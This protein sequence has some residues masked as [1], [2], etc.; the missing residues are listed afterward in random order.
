[1]FKKEPGAGSG[2]RAESNNCN[3]ELDPHLD[4][5]NNFAPTTLASSVFLFHNRLLEIA[6]SVFFRWRMMLVNV[7]FDNVPVP[8]LI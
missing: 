2:S 8:I 3:V 6:V 1:M 7:T 5:K 4:S